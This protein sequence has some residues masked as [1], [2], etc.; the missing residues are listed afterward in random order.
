VLLDR[1]VVF[2]KRANGVGVDVEGGALTIAAL[3]GR[4]SPCYPDVRRLPVRVGTRSQRDRETATRIRVGSYEMIKKGVSRFDLRDPYHLAI[5]LSWPRFLALLLATYLLVN[6]V[7]AALFWV[8]PGA[9]ANARPYNFFDLFFFSVETLATVG[10]GHMYPATFYGHFIVVVEITSGLAFTAI[11]TGLTFVRFSRPRAKLM[12]AAHPIVT[13]HNGKPMLMLRVANA[14]AGVLL[15]AKARLNVLFTEIAADGRPFR[16]ARE[17]RLERASLPVFPLTWTL[18]HV[19]DEHSPLHGYDA[20]RAL[21][22]QTQLFVILEAR[23]PALATVVHDIRNYTPRDVRFGVRYARASTLAKDG[24]PVTDLTRF[25]EI[26]PEADDREE[27][28]F[29]EREDVWD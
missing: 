8:V 15:D 13:R 6:V 1:A 29:A 23:D 27:E 3:D 21:A 28:G 18:M 22:A 12:F 14:R 5:A 10:Y 19:L 4:S 25:A 17:L 26:E 2:G 11:V 24:T 9:V 20:S 7:F 16:R